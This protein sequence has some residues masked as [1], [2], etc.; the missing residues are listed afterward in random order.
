MQNIFCAEWCLCV[1][2][3]VLCFIDL[4]NFLAQLLHYSLKRGD[5]SGFSEGV[6]RRVKARFEGYH[7][8]VTLLLQMNL[9]QSACL[10]LVDRPVFHC[11][12]DSPLT[13]FTCI[14]GS[15]MGPKIIASVSHPGIDQA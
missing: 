10:Y 8:N 1:I 13:Y 3:I 15:S 7:I 4:F 12:L 6:A 2:I 9:H 11:W 5:I 14:Y